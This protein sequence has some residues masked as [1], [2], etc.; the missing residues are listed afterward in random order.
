[1]TDN[2]S[3]CAMVWHVPSGERSSWNNRYFIGTEF[4]G[5]ES[6]ELVSVAIV[7]ENACEFYGERT[8]YDAALCSDFVPAGVLPRLGRFQRAPIPN[9]TARASGW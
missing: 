8:D 6:C 1:M 4:T 7:G 5:F 9:R 3:P 2:R